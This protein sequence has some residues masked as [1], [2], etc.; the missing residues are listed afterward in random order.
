MAMRLRTVNGVR[1]ALCAAETDAQPGDVY[2]DDADHYAI[3]LKYLVEFAGRTLPS[4][5]PAVPEADS[6]RLRNAE[7]E[8]VKWLE[9]QR[10]R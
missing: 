6:Q 10:S 4:D 2:L 7:E 5:P 3:T 1:V 8:H 9:Q